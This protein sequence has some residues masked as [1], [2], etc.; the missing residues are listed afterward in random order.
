MKETTKKA[1]AFFAASAL[2]VSIPSGGHDHPE[3]VKPQ[4][5]KQELT[6]KT[7]RRF[8]HI[9]KGK[10]AADIL[11]R[12]LDNLE[13]VF[14]YTVRELED[15][16]AYYVT[17]YCNCPKCC[18]YAGQATA[19]GIYPHF[20]DDD[21]TPTTCAI[22]PSLHSFGEVFQ[23]DGKTYIAEDTGSAIKG[24]HVDVFRSDHSEV[25]SFGSHYSTVYAVTITERK[26]STKH[27]HIKP[28]LH[29]SGVR[30]G[31]L[32]WHGLRAFCG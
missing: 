31:S 16:G 20:E 14:T 1:L 10:I 17:A 26:G 5:I 12:R 29:F 9:N 15:L 28:Y 2:A 22:D 23:I 25:Q 21:D 7:E 3:R 8:A 6:E 32:C 19:S 30:R 13:I 24:R 11:K 4:A 18:T 27:G